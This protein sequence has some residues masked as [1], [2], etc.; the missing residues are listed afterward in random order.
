M[1]AGEGSR[2]SAEL[3]QELGLPLSGVSY[4][5]RVLQ[6][7][8]AARLVGGSPGLA[9]ARYES[10]V[11]EDRRVMARLAATEAEDEATAHR[12]VARASAPGDM[13]L[14]AREN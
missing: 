8:G 3:A 10:T 6:L 5:M 13:K 11:S 2:S 4:H 14:R 1:H 7:Y 9:T 12:F